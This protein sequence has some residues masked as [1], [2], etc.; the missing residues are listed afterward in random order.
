MQCT[1][2]TIIM[3]LESTVLPFFVL[4]LALGE[5]NLHRRDVLSA[6]NGMVEDA[7]DNFFHILHS[8]FQ[9]R[10]QCIGRITDNCVAFRYSSRTLYSYYFAVFKEDLVDVSVKHKDACRLLR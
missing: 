1:D 4:K 5:R 9:S 6:W 2:D 3:Y 8:F 10:P 7:M